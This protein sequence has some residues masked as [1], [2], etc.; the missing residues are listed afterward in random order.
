MGRLER[1]NFLGCPVDR[2]DIPGIL[3]WIEE[4]VRNRNPRQIVVL[5]ANKLYL[6][7]HDV[8]LRKIVQNADLVI[9]EWAI[10]WAARRLGLPSLYHSGGFLLAK[11]LIPYAAQKGLRLYFL[12]AKPEVIRGL[13]KKLEA[14]YSQPFIAGFH[15]GYLT[16]PAIQTAALRNIREVQPDILLVGMGSPKQEFWIYNNYK[17]LN[18]PVNIGIG[19]SFDVLSGFKR[20]VPSWMRGRGLEWIYR[21][22]QAPRAYLR[23]YLV[24][25]T[26]FILQVIKAYWNRN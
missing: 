24:T 17:L 7:A 9:P 20:D 2:V 1:I 14:E 19:G 5:N 25:N 6:M 8:R 26:W 21:L 16:T 4:A 11:A 23:R 15:H 3:E 18:V 10:V 13:V 12:G 22:A